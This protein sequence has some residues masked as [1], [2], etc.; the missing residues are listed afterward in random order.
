MK[1][2]PTQRAW[3]TLLL[4]HV[5]TSRWLSAFGTQHWGLGE[6]FFFQAGASS[7]LVDIPGNGFDGPV[8]LRRATWCQPEQIGGIWTNT[9]FCQGSNRD[10]PAI[11]KLPKTSNGLLVMTLPTRC[12]RRLASCLQCCA[13]SGGR[14]HYQ[15]RHE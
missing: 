2:R 5:Q 13:A 6:H 10:M 14:R 15:S 3:V 9:S 8:Q 12:A 1:A 7:S 4:C 11:G